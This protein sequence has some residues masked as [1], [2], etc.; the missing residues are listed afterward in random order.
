VFYVT[1][2][3]LQ[4]QYIQMFKDQGLDAVILSTNLDAPFI[5]Y[6]ENYEP[7]IKFNR[8]DADI[9]DA[10]KHDAAEE[11]QP[12]GLEAL[13]RDIL[14]NDK[15][16]VKVEPLKSEDISAIILLSEQS[17]RMQE[18]SKMFGGGPLPPG[19]FEEELTLVLNRNNSLVKTLLAIQNE[20]LRRPEVNLITQ[21]LYDLAMLSHKPLSPEQ[22]TRFIQR[23]NQILEMAT[24]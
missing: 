4:T 3:Q 9:T 13:V 10:L 20:E 21:Q 6:L 22:M 5:S 15:L 7:D 17:R 1:N 11:A 8:I 12:E 2:E 14:S 18:M 16:Q 24:K 19:M 23:S